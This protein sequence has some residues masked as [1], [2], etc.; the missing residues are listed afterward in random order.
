MAAMRRNPMPKLFGSSAFF[1]PLVIA[2]LSINTFGCVANPSPEAI[3]S[4]SKPQS[5]RAKPN[6][7]NLS[8]DLK[9]GEKIYDDQLEALKNKKTRIDNDPEMVA[10]LNRIMNRLRPQT[11]IP[12][13]PFQVHYV[14]HKTVNAVCYLGGGILFF[15]GLFDPEK[16]LVDAKSD[17]EI[18][19]VMGHEMA[20][21]TLRH[22]YKSYRNSMVWSFFGNL[23]S[24]AIGAAGGT[25]W[26]RVFNTIFD[27]SSGLYFPSYS[28]SHESQ[29]D[30]E[31]MITM[32]NAGY[33][34]EKAIALWQ[35]AAD[36]KGQHDNTSIYAS[37]PSNGKR[38][39]DLAV[40]LANIRARL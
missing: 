18:A 39:H 31:G 4:S 37:H 40:H 38:A 35:R 23:A 16:G 20:H 8:W 26:S 22:S 13:I 3:S 24:I 30:F 28:R 29:A 21:A 1:I 6:L 10:R 15:H 9:T 5:I 14:D 7:T 32:M 34:P 36:K 27:I 19:A 25:D 2:V 33:N 11:L 17:D 12:D